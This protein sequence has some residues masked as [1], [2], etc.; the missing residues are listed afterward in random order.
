MAQWVKN[1]TQSPWR[2][3]LDPWPCSVG[4]GSRVALRCS[5]G[6]RRGLDPV[7]LWL[8]CRLAAAASIWPLTQE[9]PYAAHLAVKRKKSYWQNKFWIWD[10][11]ELVMLSVFC[12]FV[13][14]LYSRCLISYWKMLT[15]DLWE[16]NN[17]RKPKN[18]HS[19]VIFQN[20][21]FHNADSSKIQVTELFLKLYFF[22]SMQ[23]VMS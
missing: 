11:I 23:T 2:C 12:M 22:S 7:L 19:V 1:P 6:C 8:W 3:S 5:V 16:K 4:Y 21:G 14:I 17:W 20:S 13:I 9:Y 18:S 10:G 15:D